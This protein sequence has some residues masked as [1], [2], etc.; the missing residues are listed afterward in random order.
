MNLLLLPGNP[1][2]VSFYEAWAREIRDQHPPSRIHVCDYPTPARQENSRAAMQEIR[3]HFSNQLQNFQKA[4]GGKVTV[5]GHSL[6]G[7][8]ALQLLEL[9]PELIEEAILLYPFLRAPSLRGQVILRTLHALFP[10]E[11]ARHKLV[12][13]RGLFERVS[14]ALSEVSD[15]EL[16]RTFHLARHEFAIIGRD[17]SLPQIAEALRPRVRV[18]YTESDTWCTP[19]V[20]SALRGQVR[21][22]ACSEPHDFIVRRENRQRIWARI[23]QE[24]RS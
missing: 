14:G 13:S 6:G 8:F 16:R 21:V 4:A 18:Y 20:V 10:W 7:Y 19:Q 15:E 2:A 17:R 12:Q 11:K 22:F 1:P 3:E 9:H 5:V 24:F 23:L